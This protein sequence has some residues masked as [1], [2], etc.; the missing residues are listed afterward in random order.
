MKKQ[1]FL[2][3]FINVYEKNFQEENSF[4]KNLNQCLLSQRLQKSFFFPQ[5]S[6]DL[7]KPVGILH[8]A[9]I[10]I[11]SS[12]IIRD[13]SSVVDSSQD[14]RDSLPVILYTITQKKLSNQIFKSLDFC[15]NSSNKCNN[16]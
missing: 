16:S 10:N 11:F 14:S 4:Q 12:K 8:S 13:R 2:S 9:L 5:K 6:G 1:T 3:I 15:F 7:R